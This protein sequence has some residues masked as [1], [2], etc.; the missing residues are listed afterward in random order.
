MKRGEMLENKGFKGARYQ[1]SVGIRQKW[2]RW[3]ISTKFI[4]IQAK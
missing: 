4:E 1:P 3:H 2:Q